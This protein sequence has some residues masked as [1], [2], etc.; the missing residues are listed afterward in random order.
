MAKITLR[1]LLY[2]PAAS[3]IETI[4]STVIVVTVFSLFALLFGQ[5][6]HSRSVVQETAM[7]YKLQELTLDK[8]GTDTTALNSIFTGE[9]TTIGNEQIDTFFFTHVIVTSP[10]SIRMFEYYCPIANKSSYSLFQF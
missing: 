6:V 1:S 10:D 7:L 2:L 9:V 4:V 5:L 3:V 8:R